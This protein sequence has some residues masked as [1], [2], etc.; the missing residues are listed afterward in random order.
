VDELSCAVR[1]NGEVVGEFA[2]KLNA[3][4][5]LKSVLAQTDRDKGEIPFALDGENQLYVADDA[6]GQALKKLPAVARLRGEPASGDA[7]EKDHWIVVA[8]KDEG[9]GLRFGIARPISRA[10]RDL[11]T[12][13]AFNFLAAFFLIGLTTVGMIPLTG[14][15]VRKVQALEEGASRIAAGDLT[16][17]VPV[18][19]KDEF[20]RLA[21][22]FNHMAA[23]LSEHQERLLEQERIGKE[24]EIARRLLE[25][26]NDRKSRELEEAR[27]FQLSLL[28][29]Q[30][31]ERAG[32]EIGVAMST[33]TEVGGD[34]YDFRDGRD[35][36]LRLAIGDA[37]GHGA[38]A[39]TMVTVVKSLFMASGDAEPPAAFLQRA[40]G[41]VHGMGLSRMAMAL[42]VAEL[43]GRRLTISSAGMPPALHSRAASGAIE[44]I[45]LPGMPLGTRSEFAYAE[46]EIELAA[47]D[48]LLLMSDGF[49]ELT[50]AAGEVLGYERARTIFAGFAHLPAGEIARSL[51]RAAVEWAGTD[52]LAD[53]VTFL[54]LKVA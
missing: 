48:T 15:M 44:E 37:T 50:N 28:P 1:E 9:S 18:T 42:A 21:V 32:V 33:A 52:A 54:V 25:A 51:E 7:A 4:E 49:P 14:G 30:L 53:D 34:Y 17:R 6:D 8:R 24:R 16:T 40:T 35:G 13:T 27:R 11:K 38:A 12:E 19:S 45:A 23:Q 2:G 10:M 31:P 36:A 41:L 47:G 46:R 20:G 22:S 5:I 43:R 39:G 3:T 26:E 29:R